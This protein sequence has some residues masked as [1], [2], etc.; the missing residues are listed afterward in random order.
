M[1]KFTHADEVE[2]ASAEKIYQAS[3]RAFEAA[4]FEVW[5]QRPLAW[6]SLARCNTDGTEVSANLAARPTIPV[7]YTL[8]LSGEGISEEALEALADRFL[9]AFQRELAN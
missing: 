6:L 8:A 3:I 1:A 4:G 2:N 7:S 5:K 9:A